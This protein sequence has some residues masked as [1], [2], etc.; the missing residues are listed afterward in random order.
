MKDILLILAQTF[1]HTDSGLR[2]AHRLNAECQYHF[3]TT[4][5]LVVVLLLRV[6]E[7]KDGVRIM[8]LSVALD[9]FHPAVSTWFT[10]HYAAPT[11]PQEAAWPA[12]K[13][14]KDTLI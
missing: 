6:S 2:C 10:K 14:G 7:L 13:D 9:R 8:N 11:N 5:S 4:S 1:V 3:R 12:I